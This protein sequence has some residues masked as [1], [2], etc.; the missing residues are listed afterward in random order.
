MSRKDAMA[1]GSN[2][3]NFTYDLLERPLTET[4]SVSPTSTWIWDTSSYGVGKLAKACTNACGTADHSRTESYDPFTFDSEHQ[5]IKQA[6]PEGTTV[7]IAAGGVLTEKFTAAGTGAVTW[8]SYLIAG[9]QRIGMVESG[10]TAATVYFHTDHL[11]SVVAL[12]N[13]SATV[14]EQDSYDPWGKRRNVNGADDSGDA[15][16][17]Q[18]TRGYTGQEHLADSALIHMN[19]R[20][21]DPQLANGMDEIIIYSSCPSGATCYSGVAFFQSLI[22]GDLNNFNN[23]SAD[24]TIFGPG[25]APKCQTDDLSCITVQRKT[26]DQCSGV[27][28]AQC[29]AG[30][31]SLSPVTPLTIFELLP[32]TGNLLQNTEKD[33]CA[34]TNSSGQCVYRQGQDGKLYLDPDYAKAACDDYNSFMQSRSQ[35][36]QYTGAFGIA[37]S[38]S[39]VLG[40]AGSRGLGVFGLAVSSTMY[41]LSFGSPPPG[42]N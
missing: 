28:G 17:S 19:A 39:S 15:I 29:Y 22:Y 42:C 1:S 38:T 41:A 31:S 34:Y 11:G 40:A 16:A 20:V 13:S 24:S 12:T 35:I 33:P 27:P 4:G 37:T 8:R 32:Y 6:A 14:L 10:G 18:T 23:F 3:V 25:T 36:A 7:Y 2:T 21:Y 9:G 26:K 5:R 30:I